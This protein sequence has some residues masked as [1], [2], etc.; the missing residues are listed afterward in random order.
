MKLAGEFQCT[1][2]VPKEGTTWTGKARQAGYDRRFHH[3]LR[4]CKAGG[5]GRTDALGSGYAAQVDALIRSVYPELAVRIVNMGTGGNTVR[6]LKERTGN[7]IN[8]N[9]YA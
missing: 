9:V 6:E 1:E 4:P 5:E 7:T 2:P 8:V 3:G